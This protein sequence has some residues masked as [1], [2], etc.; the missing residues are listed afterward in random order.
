MFAVG[1]QKSTAPTSTAV[2]SNRPD[3]GWL[4]AENR[5]WRIL[6]G[7]PCFPVK[8]TIE[9]KNIIASHHNQFFQIPNWTYNYL[10]ING[11]LILH[12]TFR[13]FYYS[14]L[15]VSHKI[16]GLKLLPFS[17]WFH[18]KI[19]VLLLL[20]FWKFFQNKKKTNYVL[21]LIS[22]KKGFFF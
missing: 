14:T 22:Q 20:L 3:R 15:F 19:V 17:K 18:E 6:R 13:Y 9:A 8:M 7:P 1:R 4:S 21:Q 10:R 2:V 11:I 16:A 12:A 5:P